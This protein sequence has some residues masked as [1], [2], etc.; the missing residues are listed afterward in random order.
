M[1]LGQGRGETRELGWRIIG[2][3]IGSRK[4]DADAPKKTIETGDVARGKS[5]CAAGG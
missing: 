4:R 3:V 2:R 1:C 5:E